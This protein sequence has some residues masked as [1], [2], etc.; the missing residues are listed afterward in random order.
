MPIH[1]MPDTPENPPWMQ[2]S[3]NPGAPWVMA[4]C[5]I[6]SDTIVGPYFF[7]DHVNHH[8]FGGLLDTVVIDF[9]DDLPLD[10]RQK[11]WFQL[12]GAIAHYVLATCQKVCNMFRNHW[13]GRGG[14][15]N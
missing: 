9:V 12:D 1:R 7:E 2:P 13:I 10:T 8:T 11:I 5:G 15:V 6:L 14:P 4:W 3:N